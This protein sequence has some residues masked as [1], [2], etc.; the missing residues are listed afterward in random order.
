MNGFL[1]STNFVLQSKILDYQ[2]GRGM[3]VWIGEGTDEIALGGLLPG[4][5]YRIR[6]GHRR[7]AR[8]DRSGVLRLALAD[9]G[10]TLLLI[11]P[12]V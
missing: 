7:F 10:A 9:A 5:F 11:E 8:T 3:A 4:R 12:V 1:L 2:D 6:P